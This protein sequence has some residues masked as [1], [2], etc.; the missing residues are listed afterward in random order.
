MN[1]K[2]HAVLWLGLLLIIVRAATSGVWSDIWKGISN[3]SPVNFSG[4]SSSSAADKLTKGL[5]NA[6]GSTGAVK[7]L[8][9]GIPILSP[10]L[11]EQYLKDAASGV[12]S[13]G[14]GGTATT[15][16]TTLGN[17]ASGGGAPY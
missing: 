4:G 15:P 6:P 2:Q 13:S 1:G 11:Y 12:N 17:P 16:G 8:P 3:G 7:L 9:T 5:T 14:V 10:S